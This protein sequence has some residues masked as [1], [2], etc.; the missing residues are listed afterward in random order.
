[1]SELVQGQMSPDQVLLQAK[2]AAVYS[3]ARDAQDLI[4]G[5]HGTDTVDF[6]AVWELPAKVIELLTKDPE[7]GDE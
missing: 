2:F 7:S 3:A 1:M 6:R 5:N 4:D